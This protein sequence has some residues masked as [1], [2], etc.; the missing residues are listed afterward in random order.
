MFPETERVK[1]GPPAAAWDGDSILID[2]TGSDVGA[3]REKLAA[4]EVDLELETVTLTDPGKA[5]SAYVIAACSSLALTNVVGR[6]EPFQFTTVSLVKVV[7]LA[8]VTSRVKPAGLQYGVDAAGGELPSTETAPM[9]SAEIVNVV[10]VDV[11]PHVIVADGT[12]P[13]GAGVDTVTDTGP[14]D[15]RSV[16][17]IGTLSCVGLRYLVVLALDAPPHWM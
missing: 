6:G 11:P 7:P 15:V 10:A 5:V 14:G 17:K 13:F 8:G 16:T 4:A 1:A 9:L 3:L 2:G 12:H